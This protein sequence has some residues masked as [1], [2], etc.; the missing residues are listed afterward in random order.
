ME[1]AVERMRTE[2]ARMR[3]RAD[4]ME[5]QLLKELERLR[6]S[7][8]GELVPYGAYEPRGIGPSRSR[9]TRIPIKRQGD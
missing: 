1:S 9:G 7:L 6:G 4:Q 8:G 2:M 3:K 5:K